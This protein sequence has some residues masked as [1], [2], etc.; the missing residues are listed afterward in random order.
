MP[1][2]GS[3]AHLLLQYD[4]VVGSA[5]VVLWA[6]TLLSRVGNGKVE[7]RA[8]QVVGMGM[9]VVALGLV[10]LLAMWVLA[11][12]AGCAVGMFWVRDEIVL[13]GGEGRG[14][15]EGGGQIVDDEKNKRVL[16]DGDVL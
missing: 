9:G 6:L 3:G 10:G 2:L 7:V 15:G 5:A 12:A 1:N 14:S 8:G 16:G 13:R 11:G 4:E